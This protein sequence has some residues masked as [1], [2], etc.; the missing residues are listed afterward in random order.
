MVLAADSLAMADHAAELGLIGPDA[1]AKVRAELSAEGATASK[2]PARTV[3]ECDLREAVMNDEG[4]AA[5]D[6]PNV[7]VGT[8]RKL[9]LRPR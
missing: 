4:G 9:P 1:P 6:A 7:I 8:E 2:A 3:A 5:G